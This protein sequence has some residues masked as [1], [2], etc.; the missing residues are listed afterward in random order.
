MTGGRL[1]DKLTLSVCHF[2]TTIE[3]IKGSW[4]QGLLNFMRFLKI[5]LK[6]WS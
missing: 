1:P 5:F 6:L 3:I 2:V 4:K